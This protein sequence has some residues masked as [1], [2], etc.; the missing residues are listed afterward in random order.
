MEGIELALRKAIETGEAISIKYFG[1]SQPGSIRQI[2][3]ISLSGDDVRARCLATNHVKGFKLSKMELQESDDSSSYV[4]GAVKPEI[5]S[6]KQ[7]LEKFRS[8]LES[9]GWVLSAEDSEAGL[10]RTFK[11]GKLRKTPDVYIQFHEMTYDYTEFDDEG[12]EIEIMKPS[13]RPWYVR[14][15]PEDSS[16]TFK[17]LGGAVDKFIEFAHL[18][19]RK[20]E[21]SS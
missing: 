5:T 10:F 17:S 11:N 16:S 13:T 1:G 20:L 21:L 2:S 3:P 14:S 12:N 9:V 18:A 8:E 7:G 19:E 6:L 4:P 15:N